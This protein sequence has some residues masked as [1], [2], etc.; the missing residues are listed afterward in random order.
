[1][2]ASRY[3]YRRRGPAAG[4]GFPAAYWATIVA[5]GLFFTRMHLSVGS[6]LICLAAAGVAIGYAVYLAVWRKD[7]RMGRRASGDA[8]AARAIRE[9]PG[10][11][12]KIDA[13]AAECPVCGAGS[14]EGKND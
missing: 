13:E 8:A 11:G 6:L 9:C 4:I 14:P 1:M 3:F 5:A 2:P 7:L 10:C 12:I